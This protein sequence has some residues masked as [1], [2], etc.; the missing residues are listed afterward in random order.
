MKQQIEQSTYRKK[1]PSGVDW[2]TARNLCREKSH[3]N[4]MDMR[5]RLE[6]HIKLLSYIYIYI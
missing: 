6:K 5:P 1:N 4:N 2:H 3:N